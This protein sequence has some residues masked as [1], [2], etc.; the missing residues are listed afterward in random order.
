VF[1]TQAI[2]LAIGKAL[3]R[4]WC[5]LLAGSGFWRV[6]GGFWRVT[7]SRAGTPVGARAT[8]RATSGGARAV[9][10]SGW[11]LP[12]FWRAA[13]FWWLLARSGRRLAR[14]A[15]AGWY[16]GRCARHDTRHQRRARGRA[17][18]RLL[19]RS[20]LLVASGAFWAPSG[21]KRRRV[22]LSRVG[23]PV[24]ARATTR[25]TSGARAVGLLAGSGAFWVVS[26]VRA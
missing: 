14:N 6:L 1:V 16:A 5:W 2:A 13:G 20:G 15:G 24:G 23:T 7:L 25:A 4:A 17:S 19:A 22:T 12:G 21:A 9:R 18:A 10:A 8:I 3:A 26:P 11:R